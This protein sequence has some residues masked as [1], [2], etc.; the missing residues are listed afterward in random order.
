M[1]TEQDKPVN[2][3]P[4]TNAAPAMNNDTALAAVSTIPLI[5]L[6][7]YFA[8]PNVSPFVR[9]YE[10]QGTGLFVVYVISWFVAIIL[11]FI[12]FLGGLLSLIICLG[13]FVAWLVL[14]I[15]ALQNKTYSLPVIS[16]FINQYL[17]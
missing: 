3:T 14:L 1:P 15:N 4:T 11:A 12:P 2:I 8:M 17:K 9:H 16:D 5:G 13:L 10:K 7:L 6:I